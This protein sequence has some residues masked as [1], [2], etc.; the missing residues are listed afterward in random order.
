MES[1][2]EERSKKVPFSKDPHGSSALS[3]SNSSST[4]SLLALSSL[5]LHQIGE[6]KYDGNEFIKHKEDNLSLISKQSSH[7][8]A[9]T[10]AD[11]ID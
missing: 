7:S 10:N 5:N 9:I 3:R 6:S 1:K 11:Q 8:I 2:T 4:S